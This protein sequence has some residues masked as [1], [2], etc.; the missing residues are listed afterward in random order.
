MKK[1]KNCLLG[2]DYRNEREKRETLSIIKGKHLLNFPQVNTG[3]GQREGP[4]KRNLQQNENA[5]GR[6]NTRL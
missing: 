3:T 4:D 5:D 2:P 1:K 6:A